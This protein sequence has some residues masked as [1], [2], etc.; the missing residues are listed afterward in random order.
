MRDTDPHISRL[1]A[2]SL[3]DKLDTRQEKELEDWLAQSASHRDFYQK[4]CAQQDL[5][6]RQSLRETIDVEAAIRKFD[7]RTPS[8]VHGW[9]KRLLTGIKAAA[10]VIVIL[11]TFFLYRQQHPDGMKRIAQADI[12]PGGSKAVLVLEDGREMQ[13]GTSDTLALKFQK[14]IQ[15]TGKGEK[16][17]YQPTESKSS[18]VYNELRVP[19]GGEYKIV[20]SDGTFIH[21][22]SGTVLRYPIAFGKKQR[23]VI[24]SGEAYFEVAKDTLHPFIVRCRE[25]EVKVLGT[26]FNISAYEED[27]WSATTLLEGHVHIRHQGRQIDLLPGNKAIVT[28]QGASVTVVDGEDDISWTKD[29]F[30]FQ[31]EPLDQIFKKMARWY[32]V[33]FT[34]GSAEIRDYRFSGYIPRYEGIQFV[35]QIMQQAAPICF[36]QDG[37]HIKILKSPASEFN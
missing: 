19:R 20:L 22:N 25:Y 13:L 14:G 18:P 9:S 27:E 3:L 7:S 5:A 35:F 23:E 30:S 8:P 29:F 15:L 10:V 33:E 6:R 34:Y 28:A 17:I 2:L 32:D 4:V 16:L 31:Q 24:L 12:R 37:R 36:E 21:L 11:G 1:I 26:A